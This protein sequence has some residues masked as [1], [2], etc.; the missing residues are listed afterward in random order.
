[1]QPPPETPYT[2]EENYPERYRDRRFAT[3]HGPRTHARESRALAALLDAWARTLGVVT[4]GPWLDMPSGTGRLSGALGAPVVQ[5]DRDWGMVQASPSKGPRVCA[6]GRALP[7]RDGAF[8][9]ALSMRLF[10]HLP[11]A[12]ERRAILGELRR[13]TAGGLIVS[14]FDSRSVQHLRR[15]LRRRTGKPRSGRCAYPWTVFRA[16][17]EASGWVPLVRRPI[18]RF[19]S[20]QV[21][22]LCR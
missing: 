8:R 6:A 7:F 13:V 20:E 5:V 12:E 22:V 3:G 2:R 18:R 14:Y 19:W 21:L 10:Q 17:L 4:A 9:A 1:V 11:R 16:D 15:R